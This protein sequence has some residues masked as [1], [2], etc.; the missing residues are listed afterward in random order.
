MKLIGQL[1]N[2]ILFVS[3]AFFEIFTHTDNYPA[4]GMQSFSGNAHSK[5]Q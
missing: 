1:S 2:A 3:E 5:W 4:T